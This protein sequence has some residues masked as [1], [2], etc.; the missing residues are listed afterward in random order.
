MMPDA[1]A[2]ISTPP[3]ARHAHPEARRCS[4]ISAQ[5]FSG[6]RVGR[7]RETPALTPAVPESFKSFS[8]SLRLRGLLG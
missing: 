7:L 2:G 1:R 4:L 3:A 6:D 8:V 5:G